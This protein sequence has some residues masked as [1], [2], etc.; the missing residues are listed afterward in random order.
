VSSD[1]NDYVT[2]RQAESEYKVQP[3]I[4][5]TGNQQG[6]GVRKMWLVVDGKLMELHR[7]ATPVTA[8]DLLIKSF[9]VFHLH[10]PLAWKNVLR[11][12]Q[13]HIFQI[14]LENQRWSKFS[15]VHLRLQNFRV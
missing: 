13:V 12:L 5:A 1:P 10:F 14:P 4:L 3:Y 9:F 7:N 11:F 15:E 2:Q 8:M 6:Q